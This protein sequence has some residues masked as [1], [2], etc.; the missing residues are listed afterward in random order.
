MSAGSSLRSVPRKR[1]IVDGILLLDK[2]LGVSSNKALQQV[3]WLYGAAKGGHTGSL[4]PLATGLLPLCFGQATKVCGYLLD[5]DKS[6]EVVCRFGAR[7]T[8]GDREGEVVETGPIDADRLAALPAVLE[9]FIGEIDQI[10]PMYSALKHEG[11]RLYRLARQG[12]DVERPPRRV[13]IHAA[14]VLSQSGV[15]ATLRIRCSKG[16]YVRT[17]VEDVAVALGTVAHVHALR[18]VALGPFALDDGSH[19][20]AALQRCAEAGSFAALDDLLMPLDAALQHYPAL[21]VNEA[22]AFYLGQGSAVT[23][24]STEPAGTTVRLYGPGKRFL[25]MG[26]M[27]ADGRCAPRRLMHA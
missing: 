27:L 19:D 5:A 25:G 17:L 4:D 6:Y 2:P 11:E 16:T 22:L 8:T 3:R 12:K 14:S 13:H 24:P 18:R 15:E 26:E 21:A 10:P 20:M 9:R 1:R 7:T 23:V